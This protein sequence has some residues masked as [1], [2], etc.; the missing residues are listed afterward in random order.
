MSPR[1]S[2]KEAPMSVTIQLLFGK[3][4]HEIASLIRDRLDGCVSASLVAGFMTVEGIEAIA[5]P[6]RANPSKLQCLVVGAGTYRAYEAFDRL[7]A[8]GVSP[9]ALYVH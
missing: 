7:I 2:S 1:F 5:S 3:P 6:L 9:S 8:A 4:Q